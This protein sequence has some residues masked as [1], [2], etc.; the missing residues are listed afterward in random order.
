MRAINLFSIISLL[1]LLFN[2]CGNGIDEMEL[3]VLKLE[4]LNCS[5]YNKQDGALDE[6]VDEQ[7]K[8]ENKLFEKY[9][10]QK[11]KFDK[12]RLKWS[13]KC[14]E[15]KKKLGE[16]E[17]KKEEKKNNTS[18]A[19]I[20][21]LSL[22][23]FRKNIDEEYAIY[24][25]EYNG[26]TFTFENVY[27]T[28]VR[29]SKAGRSVFVEAVFVDDTW[30]N[31]SELPIRKKHEKYLKDDYG[32]LYYLKTNH[33]KNYRIAR[34]FSAWIELS[35]PK[36]IKKSEIKLIKWDNKWEFEEKSFPNNIGGKD[37]EF[38]SKETVPLYKVTGTYQ[39]EDGKISF[40][41]GSIREMNKKTNEEKN[42]SQSN[43]INN[44][45]SE[46][47][48][49][50]SYIGTYTGPFG[51]KSIK[52]VI[53]K[54]DGSNVSGYN[55]VGTNKRPINGRINNGIFELSEPGTDKW[56]GIFT[57]SI[58]GNLATGVWKSNNGK[59]T[60]DFSITKS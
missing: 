31:L 17:Q 41:N 40:I 15:I 1:I 50:S 51:D 46:D 26:K 27:I 14:E 22:L 42:N 11:E 23:E 59:L 6:A 8:L 32:H 49:N 24:K 7:I 45:D 19:Q 38:I 28:D 44:N 60:K 53:E 35:D 54:I 4:S 57:F 16:I 48:G 18:N 29:D 25:D 55:I 20:T 21:N 52:L 37:W 30:D 34:N 12:L 5:S 36:Q 43:N 58:K 9:K 13:R 33:G 10:D 47:N 56:D 3:D 39:N 2:S